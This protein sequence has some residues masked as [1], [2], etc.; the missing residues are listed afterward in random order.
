MGLCITSKENIIVDF[1]HLLETLINR[2][3]GV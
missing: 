1:G 3:T 2:E